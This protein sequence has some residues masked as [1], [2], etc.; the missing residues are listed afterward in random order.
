MTLISSHSNDASREDHP[1]RHCLHSEDEDYDKIALVE[2]EE[3]VPCPI[4]RLTLRM[5]SHFL[6]D[7]LSFAN[8]ASPTRL[9]ALS[10]HKRICAFLRT[11][12]RDCETRITLLYGSVLTKKIVI[13]FAETAR[14][15]LK[16]EDSIVVKS[17]RF[18]QKTVLNERNR[19][20]SCKAKTTRDKEDIDVSDAK[21]R[22]DVSD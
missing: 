8:L 11:S 1:D 7:E 18:I 22:K 14:H 10:L 3:I 19:H 20:T 4:L 9:T 16:D 13:S 21:T 6:L 5:I 2:F 15:F 17:I 12:C